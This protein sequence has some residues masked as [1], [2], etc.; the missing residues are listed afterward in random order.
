MRKYLV[1]LASMIF[2]L[3]IQAQTKFI[4]FKSHSGNMDFFFADLQ[5]EDDF[6]LPPSQMTRILKLN[7]STVIEYANIRGN[8]E[9]S[10]TVVNQIYCSDPNIGLDSL[11]KIYPGV[12]L[13]G[14]EKKEQ[15]TDINAPL[16]KAPETKTE[17]K[18]SKKK[19]K[20]AEIFA[21]STIKK[22]GPYD[23][24]YTLF[25]VLAFV[26]SGLLILLGIRLY[27]RN[28]SVA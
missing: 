3:Q 10:D 14:F 22:E 27:K 20:K 19:S 12:K 23:G 15:K 21:V 1:V 6:G 25:A 16:N 5:P 18:K 28:S 26:Y 4:A 8:R 17:L 13:E 11:Q 24:N 7:D 9:I 2:S